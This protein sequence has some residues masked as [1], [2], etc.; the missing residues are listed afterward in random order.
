MGF[1][2]TN[3]DKLY[4]KLNFFTFATGPVPSPFDCYLVLRSLKTLKIRME[5]INK[6]AQKMAHY[7]ETRKDVIERVI[8]PGLKSHPQ[9]KIAKKQTTGN[10]G[11]ISFI[12]KKGTA[13]D[14]RHFLKNLKVF[15]L[16][17]SLGG[18]ESLAEVPALM[19]HASVPKDHREKIG[20]KDG[21]IRIAVGIEEYEDLQGDIENAL[22]AV[23][24]KKKK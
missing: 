15:L 18:V 11:I 4:E 8:Y 10:G 6:N 1:A 19:T 16:A 20:I 3:S 14:S 9:H 13:G 12:I 24:S 2:M 17:E 5:A 7:L 23:K 22:N 21:L